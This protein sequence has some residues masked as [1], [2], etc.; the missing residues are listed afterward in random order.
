MRRS[1]TL[2]LVTVVAIGAFML[3]PVSAHL[4]RNTGHVGRHAWQQVIKK[5]VF[6]KKHAN[7]RFARRAAEPFHIVGTAGEPAFQNGWENWEVSDASLA[8]FY[9]DS[10]SIVHLK[11]VVAEGTDGTT[12]F[13]LP[14]G[15]RPSETL[16][17]PV[18]A[19]GGGA[20]IV[21]TSGSLSIQCVCDT[22]T[23]AFGLDGL[24]FRIGPGSAPNP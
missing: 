20:V 2:L 15:Y 19:V 22:S 14:G 21:Q 5:K 12:V 13:E 11:G 9:K 7:R 18:G 10:E 4:T 1:L 6:T 16:I 23:R 3:A 8:G 17:L 24:I